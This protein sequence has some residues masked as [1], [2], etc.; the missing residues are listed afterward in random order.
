LAD[1]LPYTFPNRMRR[2]AQFADGLVTAAK[3]LVDSLE[4]P[5]GLANCSALGNKQ[6]SVNLH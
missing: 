5:S 2:V 6:I 4:E 3:L 1:D